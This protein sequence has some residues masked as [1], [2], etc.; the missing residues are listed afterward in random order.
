M[1]TRDAPLAGKCPTQPPLRGTPIM[2]DPLAS[3]DVRRHR[4][5][6]TAQRVE[7]GYV[8]KIPREDGVRTIG[9]SSASDRWHPVAK[10]G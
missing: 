2:F 1:S 9:P 10:S 8:E 6:G 3:G 7:R 4:R 5:G